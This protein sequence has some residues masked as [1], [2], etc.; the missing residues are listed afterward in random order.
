[1]IL[2]SV[3]KAKNLIFILLKKILKFIFLFSNIFGA[4]KNTN[5]KKILLYYIIKSYI[6]FFVIFII[7]FIII[8]IQNNFIF[9]DTS[10]FFYIFDNNY[11]LK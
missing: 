4:L 5:T 2:T 9:Q 3:N 6:Y 8:I 7:G 11:N 10:K 1:L